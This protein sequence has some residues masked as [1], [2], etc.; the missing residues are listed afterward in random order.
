MWYMSE[1][2]VIIITGTLASGKTTIVEKQ[3]LNK[4]M[5][6]EVFCPDEMTAFFYK[7]GNYGWRWISKKYGNLFFTKDK[8]SVDK[9][10][11]LNYFYTHNIEFSEIHKIILQKIFEVIKG[12]LIDGK[13][14]LMEVP[15]SNI[16]F[17]KII[18]LFKKQK[19]KYLMINLNVIFDH[20]VKRIMERKKINKT[21]A[22]KYCRFFNS[23]LKL[24]D[25]KF[26]Y[27]LNTSD[28]SIQ[29]TNKKI[30][31]IISKWIDNE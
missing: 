20:Q 7:K 24:K 10:K 14:F 22:I 6:I 12:K 5:N 8:K 21:E 25:I 1:I 19:I 16:F 15:Y 9:K 4:S 29:S 3:S 2:K 13:I 31:L 17:N 30:S 11:L 18:I 27:N 26:D 23:V 28:D